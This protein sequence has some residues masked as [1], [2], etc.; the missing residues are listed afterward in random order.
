MSNKPIYFDNAATSF[1]KPPIVIMETV[2]AFTDYG[3]NPGRSGHFLSVSASREI[4]KCREEICS[5]MNFDSPERV[6]FTQNTTQAL[7]FAIKGLIK[8]DSHI[9]I[10][11]LEHNSVIRPVHALSSDESLKICYSTFDAASEDDSVIVKNF[12]KEI[13]CNTRMAVITAASNICGHLLP[14]KQ[15]SEICR[16]KG[17]SL[18]IDA[19]QACGEIGIDL[20]EINPTAIC[21]AGHK[22]LYGPPGTGFAVF[23]KEAEPVSIIQGG[24]GTMSEMPEMLGELPEM[25]EAGTLNTV[26]ICGLM[27]GIKHIKCLG[28]NEISEKTHLLRKYITD[29]LYELGAYVYGDY[30]VKTPIILF[31]IPGKSSSEVASF[32]DENGI[33]TRSGLHC[34][35]TA[36]KALATGDS[37]AV[38]VS[39]G[40]QNTKQEASRFLSVMKEYVF[41]EK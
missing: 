5:F 19:A 6:V 37:G 24:N 28:I 25:L 30:K 29:G 41:S 10:S 33:C 16:G 8:P 3:G 15:I 35:P 11:N 26:G 14:M 38:R 7:N 23:S 13:R 4:Y 31:N 2:R 34:A 12:T 36:H 1:P 39:L 20:S 27:A 32:L 9:L 40:F 17:I 18:V 21:C 22:G